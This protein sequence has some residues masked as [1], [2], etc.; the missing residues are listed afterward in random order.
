MC[1]PI[2][3][4]MG[5]GGLL[6]SL[7]DPLGTKKA[8]ADEQQNKWAREDAIRDAQFAHEKEMAGLNNRSSLSVPKSG[9][10]KAGTTGT[11]TSSR[12]G[13]RSQSSNTNRAY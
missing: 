4:M 9:T 2:A 7:G 10:G 12:G 8:R 11:P 13:G 6:E 1:A 3:G 5:A